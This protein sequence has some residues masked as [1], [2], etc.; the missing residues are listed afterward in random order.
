MVATAVTLIG[1]YGLLCLLL[2]LQQSSLIYM[3]QYTRARVSETDFEL[4]R[5]DGVIL[6]GWLVA[7]DQPDVL[8][9]FGGNAEQIG[10]LRADALALFP[11]HAVFLVAYRGYGASDGRPDEASLGADA[12]ALYDHVRTRRPQARIAVVGRSLG[13]GVAAFL[14]GQRDVDR[15]VLV[16]PFDSM[17]EVAAHHYPWLPVR[18]LLR[19]R[20]ESARHLAGHSGPVLVVRAGRDSIVPA[21]RTDALA[22]ALPVPPRILDLPDADHN[23]DLRNPAILAS[24]RAFLTR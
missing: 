24:L 4:P 12:I 20:Y 17:T 5:A 9:Y 16:T 1:I 2:F 21:A 7:P 15:L 18:W 3:P 11:G 19:E 8:L 22:A 6:R 10:H 13:S 23:V 14:A